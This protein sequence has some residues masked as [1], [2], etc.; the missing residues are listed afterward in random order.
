MSSNK[1]L[2][3]TTT[4]YSSTS[5]IDTPCSRGFR[6]YRRAPQP[7]CSTTTLAPRLDNKEIHRSKYS[8]LHFAAA[9]T[10][11]WRRVYA[12]GMQ[13][14]VGWQA[15]RVLPFL[16]IRRSCVRVL[17]LVFA[18]TTTSNK[19]RSVVT[20]LTTTLL[21][22]SGFP[23]L[24]PP[25]LAPASDDVARH[26]GGLSGVEVIHLVRIRSDTLFFFG[27]AL[28]ARMNAN[29]CYGIQ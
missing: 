21:D 6:D 10:C 18:A 24:H 26:V 4:V 27:A 20:A 29:P 25:G 2:P 19:G 11:V 12:S 5:T 23:L 16:S 22:P 7:V 17:A 15:P 3:S 13:W 8:T 14:K 1:K 9:A 28:S